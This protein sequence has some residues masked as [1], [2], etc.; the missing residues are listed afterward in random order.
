MLLRVVNDRA[1]DGLREARS[2]SISVC[3]RLSLEFLVIG[4]QKAGTTTLWKLLRDHPAAVAAGRQ[5]GALLLAHLGVRARP[6]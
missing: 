2:E 3:D 6:G 1:A 5:G 4:A